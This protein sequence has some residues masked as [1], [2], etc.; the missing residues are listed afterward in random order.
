MVTRKGL[1]M[2]IFELAR[3]INPLA[4]PIVHDRW[5]IRSI[6]GLGIPIHIQAQDSWE[7][8]YEHGR[9]FCWISGIEYGYKV[10]PNPHYSKS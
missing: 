1:T 9:E 8:T 2:N 4:K 3:E 5:T 7:F 6:N 10:Y